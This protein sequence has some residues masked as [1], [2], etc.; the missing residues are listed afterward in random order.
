M[1]AGAILGKQSLFSHP[2]CARP[3]GI[4]FLVHFKVFCLTSMTD[5]GLGSSLNVCEINCPSVCSSWMD[6]TDKTVVTCGKVTQE[7]LSR[8]IPENSSDRLT[9]P[10]QTT[11]DLGNGLLRLPSSHCKGAPCVP[12]LRKPVMQRAPFWQWSL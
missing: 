8:D 2:C 5:P 11:C 7:V 10:G 3:S 1:Y 4:P 12:P 6:R 9:N